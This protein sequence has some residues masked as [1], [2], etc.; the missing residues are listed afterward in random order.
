MRMLHKLPLATLLRLLAGSITVLIGSVSFIFA[1]FSG[2]ETYGGGPVGILLNSPNAF[3]WAL[4]L[5]LVFIARKWERA[6]GLLIT[7]FG[8][9]LLYFFVIQGSRFY[10]LVFLMTLS[11]TLCGVCFIVSSYLRKTVKE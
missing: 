9:L 3:P 8:L 4:L 7:L 6:G 1:L 2:S 5:L 10:W 11:I